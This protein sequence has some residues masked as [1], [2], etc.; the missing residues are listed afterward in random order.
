MSEIELQRLLQLRNLLIERRS[1]E[2]RQ[3]VDLVAA[4]RSDE[5]LRRHELASGLPRIELHDADRLRTQ[6]VDGARA[7]VALE[8][9]HGDERRDEAREHDAQ[10]KERRQ[11]KTERPEH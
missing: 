11:S 5:L 6:L 7:G 8:E 10:Q 9:A 1:L 2:C 4:E 3:P